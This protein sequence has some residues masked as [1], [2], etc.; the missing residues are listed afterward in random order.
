MSI[1]KLSQSLAVIDT[2]PPS[3]K[4]VENA[5]ASNPLQKLLQLPEQIKKGQKTQTIAPQKKVGPS[6]LVIQDKFGTSIVTKAIQGVKQGLQEQEAP[7]KSAIS[8]FTKW[9]AAKFKLQIEFPKDIHSL[10]QQISI[11][12][13]K[14]QQTK[15]MYSKELAQ[16][17]STPMR[18]EVQTLL[19]TGTLKPIQGGHGG[20]YCLYDSKGE[21][22][23][24][25]KPADEAPYTLNN[26]KGKSMPLYSDE[27]SCFY[28]TVQNAELAYKCAE[29]LNI[30]DI[31]PR[32]EVMIIK[33]PAFHDIFEDTIE[34]QDPRVQEIEKRF[35]ATKEKVCSVQPFIQNFHDLG[36]HFC[37]QSQLTVEELV[38]LKDEYP[39]RFKELQRKYTPF[40]DHQCYQ[41]I[42]LL[43]FAIG[44]EDGHPGNFLCE[45]IPQNKT[46][47][48]AIKIDN[49]ASF[50][51]F[52]KTGLQW[53][54][55]NYDVKD[56]TLIQERI[57]HIE[58]DQFHSFKELMAKRGKDEDSIETFDGRIAIL[59]R[60]ANASDNVSE[61]ADYRRTL[62]SFGRISAYYDSYDSVAALDQSMYDYCTPIDSYE[63][64]QPTNY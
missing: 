10:V 35:P 4:K 3:I 5:S 51:D 27:L 19:V 49:S 55:H 8:I 45:Q 38:Q 11:A 61:L 62:A 13:E 32:I 56:T 6:A 15:E 50:R 42:A 41:K 48:Q 25:L 46:Q 14:I 30:Q 16:Q 60:F 52:H 43:G 63:S 12:K 29:L 57:N 17:S 26:G 28:Q 54:V 31:T 7:N 9:E 39:S 23:Y 53:F 59:I 47:H 33:H 18:D 40:F 1:H 20:V 44:E 36:T 22:K 21:P 64:T 24:I 58:T 37:Q 34:A 2:V